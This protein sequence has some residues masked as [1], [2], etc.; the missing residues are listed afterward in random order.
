MAGEFDKKWLTGI[1]ITGSTEKQSKNDTG[2]ITRKYIPWERPAKATDV[3]SWADLGDT[4]VIV[5][6]DG[7]KYRQAKNGKNTLPDPP[8]DVT[9]T[10]GGDGATA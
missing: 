6:K 1:V 4:V 5:T 8:A 10:G 3:L 7:K 9:K 2:R